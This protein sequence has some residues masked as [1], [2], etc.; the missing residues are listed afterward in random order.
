M[1]LAG[2]EVRSACKVYGRHRALWNVSLRCEPGTSLGLLGP[3]GAGKTTLLWL[4][5]T[6]VRPTRG[7]V[8]WGTLPSDQLHSARGQ[9]ALLSHESMTY[10][11]LTG[12][13]NLELVARCRGLSLRHAAAWLERVELAEVADRPA[14]TYSRGMRQ[15]L[16]IARALMTEPSLLLLDEPFTGLDQ[17][18]AQGIE[19]LVRERQSEGG[20]VWMVT[21][22][23][24]RAA[25]LCDRFVLLRRGQLVAD[26]PGPLTE[27]ELRTRYINIMDGAEVSARPDAEQPG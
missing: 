27:T 3:N 20:M 6:L 18:S 1:P 17:R 13:E 9:V 21:H 23:L 16:S 12:R 10:E 15:R 2:V 11:D 14:K 26:I 5:S 22:E 19:A 25:R 7:E 24:S 8:R 4:L